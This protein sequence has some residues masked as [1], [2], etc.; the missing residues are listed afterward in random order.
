MR[1]SRDAAMSGRPV[2]SA[3]EARIERVDRHAS[4][5]LRGDPDAGKIV[6]D[7]LGTGERRDLDAGNEPAVMG[8]Q[9]IGAQDGIEHSGAAEASPNPITRIGRSRVGPV[10]RG[11][12]SWRT[13][14][15]TSCHKNKFGARN[16][17]TAAS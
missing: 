13:W 7:C 2:A 15:L 3:E 10:S 16:R 5:P 11:R 9:A 6:N 4:E 17:A 8:R 12:H 1:P 14:G